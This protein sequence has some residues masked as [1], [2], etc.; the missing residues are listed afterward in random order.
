MKRCRFCTYTTTTTFENDND[1]QRHARV[2]MQQFDREP[3]YTEANPGE[4]VIMPCRVFN[5]KGQCVWQKDGKVCFSISFIRFF[6]EGHHLL[7]LTFY[8]NVFEKRKIIQSKCSPFFYLF[9]ISLCLCWNVCLGVE[10]FG[11]FRIRMNSPLEF[12]L[13]NTNGLALPI[14]AIAAYGYP[15]PEPIWMPVNGNARYFLRN[16]FYFFCT[17]SKLNA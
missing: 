1:G 3:Q 6:L 13:G 4:I 17:I 5:K 11:P 16:N 15:P 10:R 2:G 9:L 12:T 7:L 14:W 8:T